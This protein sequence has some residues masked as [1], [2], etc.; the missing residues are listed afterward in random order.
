MPPAFTTHGKLYEGAA[1]SGDEFGDGL[2]N[3]VFFAFE[4]DFG[5]GAGGLY[6]YPIHGE[7]HFGGGGER[8]YAGAGDGGGEQVTH[9][10]IWVY[11]LISV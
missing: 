3:Q 8:R 7:G 1:G 2:L 9:I 11:G 10:F 4:G 5:A 6:L